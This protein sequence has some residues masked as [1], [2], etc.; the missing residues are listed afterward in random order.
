MLEIERFHYRVGG[1]EADRKG[2]RWIS[3]CRA[4]KSSLGD[5][6]FSL[7]ILSHVKYQPSVTIRIAYSGIALFSRTGAGRNV[8]TI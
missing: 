4:M 7:R 5:G 8:G 2:A 1:G 3:Y 6:Y